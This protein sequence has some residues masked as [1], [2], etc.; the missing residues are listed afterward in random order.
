MVRLT[1]K[2]QIIIQERLLPKGKLGMVKFVNTYRKI[3]NKLCRKCK[4][5]VLLTNFGRDTS[6]RNEKLS[7]LNNYCEACQQMI[8][9]QVSK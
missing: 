7:N 6:K 3:Y 4:Q 5:K 9:E 2:E 8:K 1:K